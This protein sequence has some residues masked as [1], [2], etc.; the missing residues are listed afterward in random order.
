VPTPSL[1]TVVKEE[2]FTSHRVPYLALHLSMMVT[3]FLPC[4]LLLIIVPPPI[5]MQMLMHCQFLPPI[6]I[7]QNMFIYG[8]SKKMH[9]MMKLNLIPSGTLAAS[10]PKAE[11]CV[12]VS[13]TTARMSGRPKGRA[14]TIAAPRP[15]PRLPQRPPVRR[16]CRLDLAAA[17]SC[18]PPPS[19]RLPSGRVLMQLETIAKVCRI[20]MSVPMQNCGLTMAALGLALIRMPMSLGSR[21]PSASTVYVREFSHAPRARARHQRPQTPRRSTPLPTMLIHDMLTAA[22]WIFPSA[23]S[24]VRHPFKLHHDGDLGTTSLLQATSCGVEFAVA[25]PSTAA[26]G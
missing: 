9:G 5:V 22:K 7:L 3:P 2:Y 8:D 23:N 26:S 11:E 18:P 16:Q 4:L 24:V 15:A 21:P 12:G 1:P 17:S 13:L 25:M 14:P 19:S 20:L 10:R 6:T